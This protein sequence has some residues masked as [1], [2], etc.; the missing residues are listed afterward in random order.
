MRPMLLD[1]FC[2]PTVPQCTITTAASD[3][4][5]LGLILFLKP[6]KKGLKHNDAKTLSLFFK[7]LQLASRGP[8]PPVYLISH[9]TPSENRASEPP[10]DRSTERPIDPAIQRLLF[11][12]C[13]SSGTTFPPPKINFLI[14]FITSPSTASERARDQ[15]CYPI[16]AACH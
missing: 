5:P 1:S 2:V 13:F 12:K 11:S 16:Q 10:S 8:K 9:K 7:I 3:F 14:P 15:P 4:V 6:T